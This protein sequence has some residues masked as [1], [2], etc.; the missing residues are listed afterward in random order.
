MKNF[1]QTFLL[2]FSACLTSRGRPVPCRGYFFLSRIV[3]WASDLRLCPYWRECDHQKGLLVI[4]G[5]APSLKRSCICFYV[6]SGEILILERT[7][8]VLGGFFYMRLFPIQEKSSA[9][10]A[11][12]KANVAASLLA[13]GFSARLENVGYKSHFKYA[14]LNWKMLTHVTKRTFFFSFTPGENSSQYFFSLFESRITT[15]AGW[16]L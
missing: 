11:K 13:R 1:P 14:H 16:T 4:G 15:H 6:L 8:F 12:L 2:S 10:K 7:L 5:A 9:K 3:F